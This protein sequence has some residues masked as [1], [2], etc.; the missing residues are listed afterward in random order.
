MD[1]SFDVCIVGGSL[2]GPLLALAL[3]GQGLRICV[4]D[5]APRA[6]QTTQDFD[7]R[8]Y[9]ISASSVKL[10]ETLGVWARI[11][12]S[13]QPINDIKVSDGR[14][15][16]GASDLFLH[17]DHRELDSGP[18]GYIAEDRF[19]RPAIDAALEAAEDI[20]VHYDTTVVSAD[21]GALICDGAVQSVSAALVVGCD[22][23]GSSIAKHAGIGRMG[24]DYAQM[25][26]VCSV[27]H[28]LAHDGIAHQFFM[29]T[30]PLAI[31]P[32]QGQMS[33]IV[34][35]EDQ[36][37]AKEILGFDDVTFLDALKPVFGSFLGDIALEGRRYSYPL[38]L[39]LAHRFVGDRVALAG[40]AAHG[41]HPL[42]GQGL[43]LGLRDIAALAEV[44][45][46]ARRR[47]ED[48]GA[49][50]VLDRYERWRRFDTAGLAVATDGINRLFSND[51][52]LLR[53]G[54]DLGLAAVSNLPSM[55]QMLMRE[56]AG[57]TGDM[58]KLLRG[59]A[60]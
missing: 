54:R 16:E 35:T 41:I 40:D 23:R 33:S 9:A 1:T 32:L 57:L 43:N 31:L 20:D 19:I 37:R 7:G 53:L 17:F 12:A 36:D 4:L 48:I 45:V 3:R 14:T 30:G 11:D 28:E 21:A 27:S 38:G 25:S 58:P 60:L 49:S 22:G 10:L 26:I 51:N 56:A 8:A 2:T 52:T 44:V 46:D 50:T 29:P 13:V 18:F 6:Q 15:G 39:S 55:R 47:G 42:A 24:W 5:A 34:W 59:Q